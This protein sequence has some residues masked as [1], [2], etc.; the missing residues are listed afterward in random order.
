MQGDTVKRWT[1]LKVIGVMVVGGFAI[2]G[3]LLTLMFF[4]FLGCAHSSSCF[5]F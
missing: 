3:L 1:A 2:L 4:L 5:S